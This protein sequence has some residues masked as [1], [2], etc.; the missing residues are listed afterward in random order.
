MTLPVSTERT[1]RDRPTK[2]AQQ[3]EGHEGMRKEG[4]G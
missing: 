3:S 4:P 1:E 2:R